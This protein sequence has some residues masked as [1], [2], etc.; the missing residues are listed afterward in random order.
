MVDSEKAYCGYCKILNDFMTNVSR[1]NR[2][3]GLLCDDFFERV[4]KLLQKLQLIT[5]YKI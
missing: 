1:I 4:R 5:T 2:I 3:I